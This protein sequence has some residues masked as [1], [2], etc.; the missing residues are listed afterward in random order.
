MYQQYRLELHNPINEYV[1]T[2]FVSKK[3]GRSQTTLTSFCLFLSTYPPTLTFSTY[4]SLLVNVVCERPL[5]FIEEEIPSKTLFWTQ[6]EILS[7]LIQI[8]PNFDSSRLKLHNPSVT[9][10]L[11]I[12]SLNQLFQ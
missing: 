9:N 7:F 1:I 2:L 4:P 5:T 8:V 12:E 11:F 10:N 3:R 6:S